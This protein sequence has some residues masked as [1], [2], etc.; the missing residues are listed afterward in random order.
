[1]KDFVTVIIAAKHHILDAL[2]AWLGKV[3]VASGFGNF[4]INRLPYWA[5]L[6]GCRRHIFEVA[7]Y[8]GLYLLYLFTRGLVFPNDTTPLD[9]GRRI[10]SFERSLG[11]FWEPGWQAWAIHH[12]KALVVFLNWAYIITY[13]PLVL[14]VA[15]LVYIV[16]RPMYHYY[17]NIIVI[18]L[19]IALLIF[20][21]FPAAP[22]LKVPAYF[23][24][25]IKA[26]GP[27]FYEGPGV[28]AYRNANAAMPS[29]HFS[30]TVILGVLYLRTLKGKLKLFGLLYP[31]MTF[32]AITIT[33]NHYIADAV[34][35]TLLAG[36]AFGVMELG[37]RRRLFLPW[38]WPRMRALPGSVR[39][40]P[41]TWLAGRM[42][43]RASWRL[44]SEVVAAG[45]SFKK[46]RKAFGWRG[47]EEPH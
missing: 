29:Q 18:N 47:D 34:A 35:G 5:T 16:N 15:V 6:W 27:S 20:M 38:W 23:V 25:T 41:A 24:D 45:R 1:M 30:W 11:F 43:E 26:F 31:A 2:G 28:A 7:L 37:I 17:R 8:L 32:F 14:A 33:G 22:P 46:L 13:F 19:V 10:I 44:S 39:L 40:T 21:L 9:N 36:L 3:N 42:M 4:R 12:A